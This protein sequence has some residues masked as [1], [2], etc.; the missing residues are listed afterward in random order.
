MN[1]EVAYADGFHPSVG[2]ELLQRLPGL[3][4]Q[5]FH[6]AGPVNQQ[7]IGLRLQPP[8]A[9]LKRFQCALIAVIQIP[10]FRG[11]VVFAARPADRRQGLTDFRLVMIVLRGIHSVQPSL[12]TST[13]H[14]LQIIHFICADA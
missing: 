2:I 3:L 11:K 7:H 5:P 10:D 14:A 4:I 1:L 8:N 12:K 13:D 6:R 9:F